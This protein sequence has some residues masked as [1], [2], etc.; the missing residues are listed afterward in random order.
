VWKVFKDVE[1]TVNYLVVGSI[2][3]AEHK[4][5]NFATNAS[6]LRNTTIVD[7]DFQSSKI[8]FNNFVGVTLCD[9][10]QQSS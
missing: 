3:T 4:Y 2:P 7:S 8:I 10:Q 6:P 9:L 5:N 1:V